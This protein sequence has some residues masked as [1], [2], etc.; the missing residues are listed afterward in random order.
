MLKRPGDGLRNKKE[1]V[2]EVV[3][4]F[5]QTKVPFGHC[6]V[7]SNLQQGIRCA[8]AALSELED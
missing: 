3:I 7:R 1:R 2:S 4:V 8:A 6:K 5:Q